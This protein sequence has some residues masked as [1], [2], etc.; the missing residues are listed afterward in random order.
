MSVKE[1]GDGLGSGAW[2][3]YVRTECFPQGPKGPSMD[4]GE[5]N[6]DRRLGH[7][8]SSEPTLRVR[9]RREGWGTHEFLDWRRNLTG[10]Y[11]AWFLPGL[12]FEAATGWDG[13][14]TGGVVGAKG[15]RR[16]IF[17]RATR[18]PSISTTEKR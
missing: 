5:R 12:D 13:G 1:F 11:S 4:T 18:R 16:W 15:R 9:Q 7:V 17:T 8:R 14:S 10:V 3:C 6:E 2:R